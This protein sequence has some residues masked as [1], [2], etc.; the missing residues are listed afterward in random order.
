[1]IGA[2]V[3]DI[4][5]SR[6]EFC[7]LKLGLMAVAMVVASMELADDVKY[8]DV[9][10]AET[11]LLPGKDVKAGQM[12]SARRRWRFCRHTLPMCLGALRPFSEEI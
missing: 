5:G 3:G 7:N 2:I 1:M 4:A 9:K 10:S 11:A 12:R 8:K 6:F